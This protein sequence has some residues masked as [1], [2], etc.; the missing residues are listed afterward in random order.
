M[1]LPPV[2]TKEDRRRVVGLKTRVL[3][4]LLVLDDLL[5]WYDGP[6]QEDTYKL[7]YSVS[8]RLREI[9]QVYQA[10]LDKKT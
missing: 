3:N 5:D 9:E 7:L 10:L 2:L 1:S 8:A 4:D 6:G